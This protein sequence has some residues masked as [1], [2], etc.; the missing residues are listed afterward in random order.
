M[1]LRPVAERGA[2]RGTGVVLVVPKAGPATAE[3][4]AHTYSLARELAKLTPTAVI[5]ERED[6]GP[7]APLEG[8][9][10]LVQ[11]HADRNS[12][13]RARE[14]MG[15]VRALS[16]GGVG[17]IFV[18]TSVTAAV[19]AALVTRVLGGRTLYWN[20]GKAPRRRLRDLSLRTLLGDEL[21]LRVALRLADRVVT[22][23]PGLAEHYSVTYR[24]APERVAVLPNEID[25]GRY[26]PPTPQEREA[27]R[28][29]LGV[30]EGQQLVLSIHR[31]S[32]VR[33]TLLYV[34]R[35]IER[36]LREAPGTRFVLAGGGPEEGA[37][38][39]AVRRA[40]LDSSVTC[41]GSVPH[42]TIRCLYHAADAFFMPSYTEGFPRVLLE[43]MAMGV[44]FAS[45]DVGG[46]GEIVPAPYVVRL[47]DRDDP[48]ALGEAILE[49]LSD[50]AV[51]GELSAAGLEWVRRYDAPAVA[52]ELVA[53]AAEVQCA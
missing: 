16:N 43:A 25:L 40:R 24:I 38:R 47:A 13:A 19:P 6:G 23:T 8:V 7:P 20:C 30:A 11:R 33:R 48:D 29:A 36:V 34:P 32:P 17:T 52:R 1:S 22:G 51:A 18:R 35:T 10:L 28:H 42:E 49:I 15:M 26:R 21:P 5:V 9:R 44:P 50:R 39:A 31:L 27:A 14:L 2:S 45:T 46:V 41:L 4:F 3:H 12:L 37:V 53:L